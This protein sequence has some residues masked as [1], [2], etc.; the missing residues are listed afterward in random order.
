M[1]GH[2]QKAELCC[3]QTLVELVNMFPDRG[4]KADVVNRCQQTL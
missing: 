1:L 3:R 2:I 4:K